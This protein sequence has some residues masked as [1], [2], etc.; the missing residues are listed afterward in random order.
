MHGLFGDRPKFKNCTCKK[1]FIKH[2]A[3]Y[4]AGNFKRILLL[5]FPL[6]KIYED[7]D[8]WGGGEGYRLLLS[9]INVL[10]FQVPFSSTCLKMCVFTCYGN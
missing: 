6:F 3:P 1:F 4:G 7:I 5:Q 2:T 9:V 8:F 10:K